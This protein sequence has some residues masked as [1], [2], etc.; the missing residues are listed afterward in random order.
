MHTRVKSRP[1]RLFFPLMVLTAAAVVA[2]GFAPTYYLGVWFHAP[3]LAATVHVHAAAFTAWLVLLVTQTLLIRAGR[4]RWHRAI[5]KAAVALVVIMVITGY[6]V[7]FGKPRPTA[8]MRAFIFTPILSLVLFPV[9]V[10]I[11]IYFRR[12]PAT[13]KRL[14]LLATIL[15][16]NAGVARLLGMLGWSGGFYRPWIA[17][18]GLL[19]LPLVIYDLV[20]LK[21]LHR[22]TLWGMLLLFARHPLH[23]AIAYTDSWQHLA[24]RLTPPI[25]AAPLVP[26][27]P[28]GR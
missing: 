2:A 7:I 18:Y 8:F 16:A 6:V 19:L 5:G 26:G 4:F 13:H 23:A 10:G 1:D 14:M 25:A 12:D 15:I 22:A 11:A 27:R 28:T 21:T 17:T 3:P 20:R 24:A 9:F